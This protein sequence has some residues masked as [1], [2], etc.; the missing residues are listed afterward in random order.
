MKKTFLLIGLII[1]TNLLV[2]QTLPNDMIGMWESI[3]GSDWIALREN[4]TGKL[5]ITNE[6]LPFEG[7]L[8]FTWE[9]KKSWD[10]D[11]EDEIIIRFQNKY[12]GNSD[13]YWVYKQIDQKNIVYLSFPPSRGFGPSYRFIKTR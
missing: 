10:R 6:M 2:A 3:S 8:N 1:T 7:C 12:T 5:C 11:R 9:Y 13:I 4:G